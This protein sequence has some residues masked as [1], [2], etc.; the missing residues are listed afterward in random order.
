LFFFASCWKFLPPA[1]QD[2]DGSW[3]H[4][5]KSEPGRPVSKGLKDQRKAYATAIA[6]LLLQIPLG[7]LGL[8]G[9]SR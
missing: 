8:F 5:G 6:T 1:N 3:R 7:N 4:T 2:P 9:G